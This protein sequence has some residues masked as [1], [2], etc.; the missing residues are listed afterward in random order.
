MLVSEI[1]FRALGNETLGGGGCCF[2]V[3]LYSVFLRTVA[4]G[5]NNERKKTALLM[6]LLLD[7][8][9]LEKES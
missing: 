6:L 2:S 7:D 3:G 5:Y 1:Y 9:H 4:L 8:S